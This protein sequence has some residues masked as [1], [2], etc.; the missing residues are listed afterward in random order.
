MGT[1]A[2]EVEPRRR[3]GFSGGNAVSAS[4]APLGGAGNTVRPLQNL[5]QDDEPRTEGAG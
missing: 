4:K 1:E 2:G 5:D 3:P